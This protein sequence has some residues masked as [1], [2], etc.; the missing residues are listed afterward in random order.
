MGTVTRAKFRC[1]RIELSGYRGY[2]HDEHGNV[3]KDEEGNPVVA[4]IIQPKVVLNPVSP[5][6]GDDTHENSKFW[7]ASPSGELWL[8]IN[9]PLGAEVFELNR[10]YYVDFIAAD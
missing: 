5:V 6:Q 9:N 2:Q 4:D 10:E 3:V 7:M 8:S 1:N